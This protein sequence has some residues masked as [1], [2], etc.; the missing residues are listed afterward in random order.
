[1]RQQAAARPGDRPLDDGGPLDSLESKDLVARRP[2]AVDRRRN[3]VV[4]TD[5]GQA[6]LL[7]ATQASDTAER[8]LL[9]QLDEGEAVQ[10]RAL[11]QRVTE[12]LDPEGCAP[13]TKVRVRT[14]LRARSPRAVVGDVAKAA[15]LARGRGE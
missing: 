9:G 13:A 15:A 6:K 7:E 2:D 8:E 4:L 14:C 12:A 10:F 1:M 11:L 5:A 3:V